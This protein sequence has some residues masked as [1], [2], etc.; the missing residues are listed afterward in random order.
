M[1]NETLLVISGDGMPPYSVRGVTQSLE[2]I[3]AAKNLRRTVGGGLLSLTASQFQKYK[4]TISCEDQQSPAFDTVDIGDTLTIDCVAELA[5]KTSGGSPA[6]TVVATRTANGFTF[7]RPRL[8]MK[9][10]GKSQE[11]DEYE[12][13]VSWG[14][15]LEEV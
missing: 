9:V 5:Y 14:L 3:E 11:T 4:S 1:A 12:A 10:T 2:P 8:T 15:E 7:Y 13:S 6:R